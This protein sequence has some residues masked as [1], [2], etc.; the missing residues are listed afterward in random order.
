M[1]NRQIKI[2]KKPCIWYMIYIYV[3]VVSD[4]LPGTCRPL[5]STHTGWFS[6]CSGKDLTQWHQSYLFLKDCTEHISVHYVQS[7][8][9]A[10][11]LLKQPC[12][13]RAENFYLQLALAFML[14]S[15][16][17]CQEKFTHYI[18]WIFHRLCISHTLY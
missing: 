4:I 16:P 6:D 8:S 9:L 7:L 15:V 10:G 11:G 2:T 5:V 17:T 3:L 14:T 1:P 13:A 18:R 12:I